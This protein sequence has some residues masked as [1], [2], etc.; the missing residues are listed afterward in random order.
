MKKELNIKSYF[1]Y[2]VIKT[3]T[4][5]KIERTVILRQCRYEK[6]FQLQ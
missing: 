5:K 2:Y 4:F 6:A 1:Y 3:K